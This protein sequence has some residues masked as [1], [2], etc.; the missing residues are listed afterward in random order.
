MHTKVNTHGRY[1]IFW[2]CFK[3]TFCDHKIYLTSF[4][5]KGRILRLKNKPIPFLLTFIFI[6]TILGIGL[7]LSKNKTQQQF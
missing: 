1:L 7:R 5:V 4:F 3:V 2:P 6:V